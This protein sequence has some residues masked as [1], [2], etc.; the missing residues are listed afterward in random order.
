MGLAS[1][2]RRGCQGENVSLLRWVCVKRGQ[3]L[4]T[5]TQREKPGNKQAVSRN[6]QRTLNGSGGRWQGGR[7]RR[8]LGGPEFPPE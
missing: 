7:E 8:G 5:A 3:K 6:R 2:R 4:G 1:K